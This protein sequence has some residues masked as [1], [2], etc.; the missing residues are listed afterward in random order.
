M[1]H[2]VDTPSAQRPMEGSLDVMSG[3]PIVWAEYNRRAR[4]VSAS[5]KGDLSTDD[6][7]GE[8][9]T[10]AGTKIRVE[11]SRS[12]SKIDFSRSYFIVDLSRSYFEV[13]L[14]QLFSQPNRREVVQKLNCREVTSKL[15]CREVTTKLICREIT[16]KLSCRKVF[17]RR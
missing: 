9:R 10:V 2:L 5:R 1:L 15:I 13:E 8:V 7:F 12:C 16:S 14:S 17:F 4:R 6:I 3:A 11:L